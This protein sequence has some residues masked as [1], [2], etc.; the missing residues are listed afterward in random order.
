MRSVSH[1]GRPS[2]I[3]LALSWLKDKKPKLRRADGGTIASHSN[4]SSSGAPPVCGE[5]PRSRR[6]RPRR[7]DCRAVALSRGHFQRAAS[8]HGCQWFPEHPPGGPAA[9]VSAVALSGGAR[10]AQPASRAL[11]PPASRA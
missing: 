9:G 10:A 11:A 7:P 8:A 5:Q 3:G 2:R 6:L 4:L 1:R